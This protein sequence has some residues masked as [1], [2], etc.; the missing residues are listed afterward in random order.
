MKAVHQAA[1]SQDDLARFVAAGFNSVPVIRTVLAD[2]DTPVSSY[3]K[4]AN[5][6]WSYLLESVTGGETWGR[7]SIIG[8]PCR[9][10]VE[11]ND[12]RVTVIRDDETVLDEEVENPL[13]WID[14]YRLKW[15]SPAIEDMPS[16]TGGLVGYFGY[17][18]I[19]YIEPRLKDIGNP[20]E[21]GVPDIL[22]MASEDLLVFDN[23]SSR[24]HLIVHVD[25]S[26]A[27][28]WGQAQLR[29]DGLVEKLA[30]PMPIA[31][32]DLNP[33]LADA[34][35]V[36][37]RFSS[38]SGEDGYKAAVKR[39]REYIVEGDVM[40][41]VPSQRMTAPF[42]GEP[43]DLYRAL[44]TMNPSPYMYLLNL[45]DFHVV[46]ASPE[47]LVRSESGQVT[48]RPI[49]GTRPRGA[50]AEEDLAL[51]QE[52]IEDPKEIAEHLMLIDLGRNDVG[53]VAKIGSVEVCDKMIIERYSHV[54]HIVSG[55]RGVLADGMTPID[56]L[57][58]TFPAG[59]LS[60]ASKVRALEVIDEL[61]PV[62]RNIY[63]GAV[64]YISWEGS[65]DTAIA[66]R[67][68]V[69]KDN[70]IHVQAG[71]GIVADSDPQAEWEETLNKARAVMRAAAMAGVV[72]DE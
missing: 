33:K 20:D 3:L 13:T 17:E 48:V 24:I 54:M 26:E 46:G 59:T 61:E 9:E 50:N 42:K 8:L 68:A 5:K 71:G 72:G 15:N 51:A 58:A 36:E 52:L 14:E 6:P 19:R 69:I 65:M 16:L 57:K 31:R 45:G 27:D 11:V 37:A 23:L 30:E 40:Q 4:L 18:I 38:R 66:I 7:Y 22:L 44:R 49:A 41:V 43:M 60:G 34:G 12:H 32:R 64:G 25:P 1:S 53:R 10:R 28:A 55:V 62:K 47:I 39:I 21:L 63:G 35:N 29:L 70:K 56:V 67:T 2:V